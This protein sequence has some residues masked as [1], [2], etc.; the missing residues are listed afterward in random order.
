MADMTSL[1][2]EELWQEKFLLSNCELCALPVLQRCDSVSEHVSAGRMSCEPNEVLGRKGQLGGLGRQRIYFFGGR[3]SEPLKI[4]NEAVNAK[5]ASQSPR[6]SRR[7]CASQQQV[8]P[9]LCSFKWG[10]SP[11]PCQSFLLPKKR[12]MRKGRR[13]SLLENVEAVLEQELSW[14]TLVFSVMLV[15]V[16]LR[17]CF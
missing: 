3:F 16:L 13:R 10:G 4:Q 11:F 5:V 6:G 1:R 2:S 7:H 8:T 15:G 9:A 14:G 12:K 17:T